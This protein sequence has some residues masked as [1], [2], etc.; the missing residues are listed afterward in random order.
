MSDSQK[1]TPEEHVERLKE[2]AAA[3]QEGSH[4]SRGGPPE[5]L[6]IDWSTEPMPAAANGLQ[7]LATPAQFALVYTDMAPFPGRLAADGKAGHERARVVGSLRLTPDVYFQALCA[8]ANSWN[9]F[10]LESVDPRMRQPRFKLID[11]GELQLFGIKP[12]QQE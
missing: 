1:P 4:G 7:V 8:M 12:P 9:R 2:M 10:V 6:P 11:S 3:M 5:V